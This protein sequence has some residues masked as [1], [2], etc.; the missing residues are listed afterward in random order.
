MKIKD[1]DVKRLEIKFEEMSA[2]EVI[3]WG[4]DTFK[5]RISL[6]NSFGAEDMVLTNMVAKIN[7]RIKI[8][9]LDTGR[10]PQESYKVW[11]QLEE[12]YKIHIEAYFPEAKSV[13]GMVKKDGPNLFYKSVN[14]RRLC[15]KVRKIEPLQRA[16]SGILC[17][18]CGLRKEQAATRTGIK[19]IEIDKIHNGIVKLNPLANW[20][21]KQVWDYIKKNKIPYNKL[22]DRNYPSIGCAPCTRP[23]KPGEDIRAGRWWWERPEQKECGLHICKTDR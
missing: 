14:L 9:T 2:E 23:I 7:P 1:L 3:Q 16:L 13:E 18:I 6:A 4:W 21:E 19:K 22:H 15:C 20:T 12:K 8:F 17:W 11:E 10:L 5:G